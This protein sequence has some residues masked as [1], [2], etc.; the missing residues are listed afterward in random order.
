M[1]FKKKL[2]KTKNLKDLKKLNFKVL[3]WHVN[4]NYSVMS[5][6]I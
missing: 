5:D 2:L 1:N 3:K 4:L 6:K